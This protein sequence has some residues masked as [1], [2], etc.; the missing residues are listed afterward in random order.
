[1]RVQDEARTGHL[2]QVQALNTDL[3][4][5]RDELARQ[6]A[7]RS[8]NVAAAGEEESAGEQ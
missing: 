4:D 8:Q 6:L 1:M 5:E 3:E 2:R 7:L